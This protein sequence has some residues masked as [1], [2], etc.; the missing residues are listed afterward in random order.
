METNNTNISSLPSMNL[1]HEHGYDVYKAYNNTFD[2][3]LD[4]WAEVEALIARKANK[5]NYGLYR[6]WEA[7]EDDAGT[8]AIVVKYFDCGPTVY[9]VRPAKIN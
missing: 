6:S 9:L 8:P 7:I 2:R 5:F 1:N 3:H 4:N